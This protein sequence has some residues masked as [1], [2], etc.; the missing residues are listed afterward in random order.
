M[1]AT[2]KW[3]LQWWSGSNNS[4]VIHAL[5]RSCDIA[6]KRKGDYVKKKGCDPHMTRFIL[7][8]NNFS[9][10]KETRIIFYLPSYIYI[11]I[12]RERERRWGGQEKNKETE[13]D[14]G[15][16]I[17]PLYSQDKNMLLWILRATYEYNFMLNLQNII[18]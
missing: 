3:K 18:V 12:Y 8:Y 2:K 11:Y 5:I 16:A 1:F 7:M 14:I 4:K 15:N 17:K 6:I 10:I 13:R 9:C